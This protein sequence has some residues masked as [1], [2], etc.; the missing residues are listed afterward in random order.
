[1]P[2][3]RSA[4]LHVDHVGNVG[5]FGDA[6]VLLQRAESEAGYGPNPK[7]LGRPDAEAE[8]LAAAER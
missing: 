2:D 3:R 1:M 6:T 8:S 7:E 5:L 4:H